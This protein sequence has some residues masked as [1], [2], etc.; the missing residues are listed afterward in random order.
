MAITRKAKT[1]A[2]A[3]KPKKAAKP[4]APTKSAK[5]STPK[6][7]VKSAK[8]KKAAKSGYQLKTAATDVSVSAF[9]AKISD[10]A[11]RADAERALA[12]MNEATGLSPTMWGASIIG[13]GRYRYRNASGHEGE[14]CRTGFSPRASS[15][16][17]YLMGGAPEG[18]PLFKRLGKYTTGKS[19][20]Y[21]KRLADVDEGVL[22]ALVRQSM[23]YME[24]T[25]PD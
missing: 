3:P 19:C 25:Y 9:I 16:V 5:G 7:A 14:M 6:K 10:P 24:R 4:A 12:I 23:D 17:F 21:V 8:P 13:Y 11:R 22:R 2:N 20:L 15:L 18:D 1:T